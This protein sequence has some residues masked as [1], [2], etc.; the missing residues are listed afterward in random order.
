MPSSL[1]DGWTIDTLRTHF[2]LLIEQIEKKNDYRFEMQDKAIITA[3]NAQEKAISAALNATEKAVSKAETAA[4]KRFESVNEFRGQ[5]ADQASTFLPRAEADARF[6]AIIEKVDT[7][8]D[9]INSVR[10]R[11]GGLN[12][13]WG[14]LTG[15]IA[16]ISVVVG[17]FMAFSK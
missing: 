2:T 13:G 3:L 5:L 17:L 9:N 12:A 6:C 7:N 14:Y 1:N 8:T 15:A 16:L 11:S 10:G 4:E